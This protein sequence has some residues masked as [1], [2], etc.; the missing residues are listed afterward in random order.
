[1]LLF[2]VV[3]T[4]MHGFTIAILQLSA[5]ALLKAIEDK[6]REH[7][8]QMKSKQD[9]ECCHI[10]VLLLMSACGGTSYKDEKGKH[11][12]ARAWNQPKTCCR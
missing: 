10:H 5:D 9:S 6:I 8:N 4:S 1:M 3:C 2:P 12:K 11:V 7:L